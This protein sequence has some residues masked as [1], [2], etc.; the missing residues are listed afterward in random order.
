[1]FI[2][3]NDIRFVILNVDGLVTIDGD[4]YVRYAYK[5]DD[6]DEEYPDIEIAKPILRSIKYVIDNY[7]CAIVSRFDQDEIRYV[8]ENCL[9][10]EDPPPI[11]PATNS[12][13]KSIITPQL[14]RALAECESKLCSTV[15]FCGDIDTINQAQNKRLGTIFWKDE[16]LS[17]EV[18]NSLFHEGPDFIVSKSKNFKDIFEKKYLGYFGEVVS[19]PED[20]FQD[21]AEGAYLEIIELPNDE[22]EDSAI[23][24]SGRYFRRSDPRAQ[25]HALSLRII[26]SKRYMDRQKRLFAAI[27]AQ[28]VNHLFSDDFDC[29]T[30][31]PPKPSQDEDRLKEQL[32]QIPSLNFEDF[33]IPEEKICPDLITCIKDYTP[34]KEMGNYQN[35]RENV[36]GVFEVNGDVTDKTI[37][38]VD[39]IATSCSTLKEITSVLYDAGAKRVIPM[40][41]SYHPDNVEGS[42]EKLECPN[43]HGNMLPR[44]NKKNGEPFY[45]CEHYFADDP[46]KQCRHSI[47]FSQGVRH[48][49]EAMSNETIDPFDDI[50]F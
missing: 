37:V 31:V 33:K 49:N 50:D 42:W 40:A 38:V 4:R 41:I 1:M 43:C 24:V 3:T 10:I 18:T 48:L 32:Q 16:D 35:R 13:E 14:D 28:M 26:N 6:E 44:H 21:Q 36:R 2:D 7:E 23:R 27:I 20:H 8:I 30:R 5:F 34:Q 45:G 9:E 29:I 22:R 15:Y 12:I 25:K 19:T 17:A 46:E 39:D 11:Y 47:R